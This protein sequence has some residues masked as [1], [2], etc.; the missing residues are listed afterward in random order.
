MKRR[1]ERT[2]TDQAKTSTPSKNTK[3]REVVKIEE[4]EEE[5]E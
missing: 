1:V 3:H 5:E 2:G 4:E